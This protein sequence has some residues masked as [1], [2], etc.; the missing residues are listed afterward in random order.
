MAFPFGLRNATATVSHL[1]AQ[2]TIP[3]PANNEFMGM[4]KSVTKSLH[5]L[6]V[7]G[8]G[9]DSGSDSGRGSHHPSRECFM[10]ETSEGHVESA[11]E[12]EVTPAGN[13]GDRAEG[14]T[15]SPPHVGVE[16]LKAQK[17]EINEARQQLVREYAL[18]DR[19]IE[20]RG[21]GGHARAVAHDVN[22]RIITDDETL[23]RFTRASHN[24]TTTT[25]L[26]HGLPKAA[27]PEDRQAHREIRTLLKRAAA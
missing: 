14:R 18:V 19:E 10:A 25:A 16:Q 5:G 15:E 11:S 20:R 24:I 7:E 6:L 12:K 3:P 23:P 8:P 27:T 1:V 21:D 4:I 22:Q 9:S 2:R 17:Q 26:L 13:L